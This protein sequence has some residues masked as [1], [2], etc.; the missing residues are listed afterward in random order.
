MVKAPRCK[1]NRTHPKPVPVVLFTSADSPRNC[2]REIIQC[3]SK[4]LF[5]IEGRKKNFQLVS[6]SLRKEKFSNVAG[7]FPE[8]ISSRKN[9]TVF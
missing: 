7:S 9:S 5:G 1:I 2:K 4:I 3:Q 8:R 6:I